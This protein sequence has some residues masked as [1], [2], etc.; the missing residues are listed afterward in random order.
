MCVIILTM[1]YFLVDIPQHTLPYK[2]WVPYGYD[3]F[4]IVFWFAFIVQTVAH[5]VVGIFNIAFDTLIP[6]FLMQICGQINI[7]KLRLDELPKAID[8]RRRKNDMNM[9]DERYL[10]GSQL[11]ESELLSECI[12]HHLVIFQWNRCNLL[13]DK[14][15][16]FFQ[17]VRLIY[18]YVF[19]MAENIN[20]IFSPAVLLQ[21]S[22]SSV[23]IC[24][25][26]YRLSTLRLG[27]EFVAFFSYMVCMLV[28][29]F[30]Y[31]FRGDQ[32]TQQVL[33]NLTYMNI[34]YCV[35]SE[36][37]FRAKKFVPL[38]I[39]WT[40]VRST[41]GQRNVWWW[42]WYVHYDLSPSPAESISHSPSSHLAMWVNK[43]ITNIQI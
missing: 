30:I 9:G 20:N 38:F 35:W 3:S 43:I 34:S 24:V 1:R 27:W 12:R 29:I 14:D 6:G 42:L 2:A 17:I 41:S 22:L 7:L 5:T 11:L 39:E 4:E 25:S 28:Q 18:I 15:Y 19:R 36:I 16:I 33:K 37:S 10:K 8:D 40:G 31:C 21:Y 32:I 23:V 13:E 26:V